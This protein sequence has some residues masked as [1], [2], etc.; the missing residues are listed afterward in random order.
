MPVIK[1]LFGRVA[2]SNI[3]HDSQGQ[4]FLPETQDPEPETLFGSGF[5]GLGLL[6]D[7]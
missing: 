3:L 4:L 1:L 7:A 5:A 6:L 2:N